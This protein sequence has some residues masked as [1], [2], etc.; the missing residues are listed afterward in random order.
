MTRAERLLQLMQL[1]RMAKTP[2]AGGILADSLGVSLRTLYRDIASLQAQGARVEGEAGLGYVLRGGFL[3][4]P[5]MFSEE[6][7]E[8]LALGLAWVQERGDSGMA[9]AARH[10]RV[11][12]AAVLPTALQEVFAHTGMLV[13]PGELV[14]NASQWLPEVRRAIR[15]EQKLLL[16]YTDGAGAQSKR[17]VWPF[18]I[19]FFDSIRIISAWCELR[20]GFRHFRSD[21]IRQLAVLEQGYPRRREALLREWME[22]ENIGCEDTA[23]KN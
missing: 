12:I 15:H 1:L 22:H 14:K 11:K 17:V 19:G 7:L 6:E 16:T 3:L 5:L 9:P 18:A 8:A 4:P 21:R 20:Q 2:V 13:G 23:D 10:A